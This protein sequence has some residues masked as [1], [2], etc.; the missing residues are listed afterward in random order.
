M[1][2]AAEAA[3]AEDTAPPEG[4][5]EREG[6]IKPGQVPWFLEADFEG[7]LWG[8][9]DAVWI[10]LIISKSPG[11][12]NLSKLFKTI[13]GQGRKVVVPTPFAHMQAILQAKGFLR[14]FDNGCEI[15]TRAA[16]AA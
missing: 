2:T 5:I 1:A 14:S 12:C 7:Y 6:M 16:D 9:E 13:W 11:S 3:I 15:W 10:S 4:A 8:F